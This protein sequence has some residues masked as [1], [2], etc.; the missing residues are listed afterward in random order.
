DGI[1][2]TIDFDLYGL[3][4]VVAD[5]LELA[6]CG[7]DDG[8]VGPGR[9][10]RLHG[11]RQF[12]LLK[13]VGGEHGNAKT[14]QFRHGTSP[15]IERRATVESPCATAGRAALAPGR[16]R[17]SSWTCTVPGGCRRR[18][19]RSGGTGPLSP[20]RSSAG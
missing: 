19:R 8:D 16:R 12:G 1:E 5:A 13:P 10:Q 17:T 6:G 9:P 11:L 20:G 7:R 4:N 2:P 15:E 14:A 3:V 18:P